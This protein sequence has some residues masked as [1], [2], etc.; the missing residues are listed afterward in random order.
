MKE[1]RQ[2]HFNRTLWSEGR[3]GVSEKLKLRANGNKANRCKLL[4]DREN[5]REAFRLLL[6]YLHSVNIKKADVRITAPDPLFH[7]T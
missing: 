2:I 6:V 5:E 1:R 3:C 4:L 7:A